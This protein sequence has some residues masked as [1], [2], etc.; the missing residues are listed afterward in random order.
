MVARLEGLGLVQRQPHPSDG[1]STW[2][3]LTPDGVNT[4]AEMARA[5]GRTQADIFRAVPAPLC[6]SAADILRDVLLAMGDAEPAKPADT[7]D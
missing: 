4:S 7:S 2:V 3:R 6:K 5:W 1:R